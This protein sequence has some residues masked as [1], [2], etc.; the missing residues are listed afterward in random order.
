MC[1]SLMECGFPYKSVLGE[2]IY[3]FVLCRVDMSDLLKEQRGIDTSFS[4][5]FYIYFIE[6]SAGDY[7]L[8]A[9]RGF[10]RKCAVFGS[11]NEQ[12]HQNT[13]NVLHTIINAHASVFTI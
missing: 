10:V 3:P 11:L 12:N 8:T 13:L 1:A 4:S 9:W 2:L 6:S 5:N 7:S